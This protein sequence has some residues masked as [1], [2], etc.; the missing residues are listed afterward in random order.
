MTAIEPLK[1][2]TLQVIVQT[3]KNQIICFP[4]QG[5]GYDAHFVDSKDGSPINYIY[6]SCDELRH[7]GTNY[8]SLFEQD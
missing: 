5:E 4:P 3:W 6:A 2:N 8:N 1:Q 7:L